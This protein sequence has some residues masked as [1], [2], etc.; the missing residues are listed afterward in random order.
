MAAVPS[1]SVLGT[2]ASVSGSDELSTQIFT[3]APHFVLI[4]TAG[5]LEVEKRRWAGWSVIACDSPPPFFLTSSFP[6][7]SPPSIH[8]FPALLCGCC[9][10]SKSE[11]LLAQPLSQ[12]IAAITAACEFGLCMTHCFFLHWTITMHD[13]G[14]FPFRLQHLHCSS[15]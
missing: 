12:G 2:D 11:E 1:R 4:S 13:E 7:L 3:P 15:F 14:N 9:F 10:F 8:P 6:S 5:V